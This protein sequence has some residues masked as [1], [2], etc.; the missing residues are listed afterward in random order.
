MVDDRVTVISEIDRE[1]AILDLFFA[2]LL[3]YKEKALA[4][5][6]KVRKE[7]ELKEKTPNSPSLKCV[8]SSSS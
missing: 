1:F 6:E 2:A 8:F 3:H 7:N 4:Q 5:A